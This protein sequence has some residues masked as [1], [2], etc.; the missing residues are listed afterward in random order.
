MARKVW[1]DAKQNVEHKTKLPKNHLI[2]LAKLYF[3]RVVKISEL[4][5]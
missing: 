4:K 5:K 1:E 2:Q 3:V